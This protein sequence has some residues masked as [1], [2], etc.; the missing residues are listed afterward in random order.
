[1]PKRDQ[2]YVPQFYLRFFSSEPTQRTVSLYSLRGGRIVHGASIRDQCARPWFYG[3]D[4]VIEDNLAEIES[5]TAGALHSI[6]AERRLPPMG[7]PDH[8]RLLFFAAVQGLRTNRAKKEG[9]EGERKF[10]A[11]V[12]RGDEEA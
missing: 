5:E 8:I 3:K 1:M 9:L 2:H 11:L 4:E 10:S 6:R 7:T 12:F